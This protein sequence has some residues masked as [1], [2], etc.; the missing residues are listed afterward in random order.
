MGFGTMSVHVGDQLGAYRAV[1]PP[2]VQTATF[3]FESAR[4]F[5]EAANERRSSRFYTRYGNPNHLQ[6]AQAVAALEGAE[7]GLVLASGMGTVATCALA[8]LSAGDHVIFQRSTYGGTASLVMNLLA[9]LGITATAVAQSDP[10]AFQSAITDKTRLILLETPSNPLLE[11]TDLRIVTAMA[12]EAG[13]LTIA[14]NT[15]ATPINSRPLE[16]GVDLVWHSATKYLAGHSDASAG[17]VVGSSELLDRVWDT[18]IITGAVL[19]PF[20][21]WLLLRGIRT[22]SL[23]VARHNSNGLALA[24]A[25]SGHPAV[26]AVHY[27]GLAEHPQHALAS[28]QMTGYG[29][30]LSFELIGGYSAADQFINSLHLWRRAASVGSVESLVVHPAAMWV[31]MLDNDQLAASGVGA[32]LVRLAA[33]IEDT[34][35]LVTDVLEALDKVHTTS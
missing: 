29:G 10:A 20:D 30:V 33:G 4:E 18:A 12:R 17:V 14:D 22:L 35:D 6:V 34:E 1:A 3:S 24:R 2:I 16:H 28:S 21:A 15:F 31:A 25:I 23:R 13:V 27:P 9:R 8:L 7:S 26:A 19:G 32:G 5:A 11:I